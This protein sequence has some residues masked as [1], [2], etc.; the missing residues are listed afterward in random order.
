MSYKIEWTDR[1]FTVKFSG[2]LDLNEIT[3]CDSIH[4]GHENFDQ[5]RYS[6]WDFSGVEKVSLSE[7]DIYYISAIDHASSLSNP[8]LKLLLIINNS[9][10]MALGNIYRKAIEDL[11]WEIQ[12]FESYSQALEWKA[13]EE[14]Q[15]TTH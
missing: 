13:C 14:L 1:T 11:P 5:L 15:K 10:L 7:D 9:E 2:V 6:I 8:K 4:D 3:G 12:I